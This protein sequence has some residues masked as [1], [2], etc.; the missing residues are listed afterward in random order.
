MKGWTSIYSN[1]PNPSLVPQRPEPPAMRNQPL[2]SQ[3]R[4]GSAGF[5]V[6]DK[7]VSPAELITAVA[8]LCGRSRP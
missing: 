5:V 8:S 1:R 2:D 3:P 7:P 6:R 4:D